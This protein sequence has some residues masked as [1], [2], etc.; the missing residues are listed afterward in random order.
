MC[1][2]VADVARIFVAVQFPVCSEGGRLPANMPRTSL[3]VGTD[4]S[5]LD[6]VREA[7]R[8]IGQNFVYEFASDICPVV[9]DLLRAGDPAPRTIYT[10]V[11]TRDN[12]TAPDVDLYIA[13]FKYKIL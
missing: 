11:T 5:G 8:S 2:I 3:R 13:G 9:R 12:K 7:L 1:Q 10:D 4:C 6:A